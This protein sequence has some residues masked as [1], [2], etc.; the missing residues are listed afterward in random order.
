PRFEAPFAITESAVVR[1]IAVSSSGEASHVTTARYHKFPN[2]WA[3]DIHGTYNRQYTA[4]GDDGIIDGL[5]GDL[6]WRKGGW[7]GYQGQD[8]EAVI[9]LRRERDV[10]HLAAGFLQDTRSWIL[11]PKRVVFSVSTDGRTFHDVLSVDNAVPP[12]NYSAQIH[13]LAGDIAPVHARFV[14]VRA[15]NFGTLPSWH[16]GAGDEAFIFVDEIMIR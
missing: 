12:D 15:E 3:I 5:R 2:D 10:T 4:G 8:F 16:A 6:E 14:R 1:A 7:Q 9:D 13:D 11:M